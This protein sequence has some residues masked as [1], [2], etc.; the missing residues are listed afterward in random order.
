VLETNLLRQLP[1]RVEAEVVG[2]DATVLRRESLVRQED[3]PD[4]YL[5]SFAADRLGPAAVRV[6]FLAPGAGEAKV[7]YEVVVPRLELTDP[8]VDTAAL[9]RLASET[10]GRLVPLA[11]AGGLPG[12]IPSAAKTIPV[13]SSRPLWDAPVAMALFVLLITLEWVA[14]KLLGML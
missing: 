9:S 1:E 14:R 11:E 4:T 2:P 7:P 6:P 12:M 8:R 10:G 3:R 13:E 5:G